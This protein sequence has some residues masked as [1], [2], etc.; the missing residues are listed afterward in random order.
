MAGI[1]LYRRIWS[2]HSK[3][4]KKSP[5]FYLEAQNPVWCSCLYLYGQKDEILID[6]CF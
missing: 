2:S 5:H 4:K 6:Y 1:V 3:R